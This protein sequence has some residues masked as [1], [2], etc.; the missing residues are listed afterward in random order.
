P[1]D[2]VSQAEARHRDV[3][4][5]QV[6]HL[7][8]NCCRVIVVRAV[9]QGYAERIAGLDALNPGQLVTAHQIVEELAVIYPFSA[10]TYWQFVCGTRHEDM[11]S[12]VAGPR[13][14]QISILNRR[15]ASTHSVVAVAVVDGLRERIKRIQDQTLRVTLLKLHSSGVI[16]GVPC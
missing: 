3:A 11:G 5:S 8:S 2:L 1:S 9:R 6:G 16:S 14:I 7:V 10:A 15:H 12:I 4:A 13:L